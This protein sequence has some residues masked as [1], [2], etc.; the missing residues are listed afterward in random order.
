MRRSVRSAARWIF[1]AAAAFLFAIV[2]A[3]GNAQA[4]TTSLCINRAGRI[5]G[6]DTACKKN[7]DFL[8][9]QTAGYPGTP[10]AA[11]TQ[12]PVGAAGNQGPQGAQ[13]AQGP[14]GVAGATGPAGAIGATGPTGAQ[15][16]VG[17]TGPAGAVGATGATGL[18]GATGALGPAGATGPIGL[19]GA[20]G[21]QGAQ[22]SSGLTGIAGPQGIA[23]VAGG[24]GPTG[25]NGVETT[26]L[27]GG[28][29]GQEVGSNLGGTQLDPASTIYLGPNDGADPGIANVA[30]PL[31]AG[32]IKSLIVQV[33]FAPG[34]ALQ[35]DVFDVCISGN[36]NTGVTCTITGIGQTQC[37]D[38]I[39]TATLTDGQT[40]SLQ[41]TAS[42]TSHFTNVAWSLEY[43]H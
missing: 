14:A 21:P 20:Q 2:A 18:V 25:P 33:D 36:C 31:P 9:W 27:V 40:L 42:A 15:G 35:T 29:F 12:G 28:N 16:A 26:L 17:P 10:G 1:G 23:G 38:A 19:T 3:A 5:K 11:G 4:Q 6:I 39:D 30:V 22:G 24:T 34:V 43:Q 13:G 41:A 37:T 32:T 8:A 7:Q